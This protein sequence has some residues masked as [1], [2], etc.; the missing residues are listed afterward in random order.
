MKE[1]WI[2]EYQFNKRA[3]NTTL[4]TMHAKISQDLGQCQDCKRTD[5]KSRLEKAAGINN[6]QKCT[7]SCQGQA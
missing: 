5:T 1:N 7:I 6:L 4:H 3:Y 2:K